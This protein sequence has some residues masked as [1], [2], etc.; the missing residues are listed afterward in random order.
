MKTQFSPAAVFRPPPAAGNGVHQWLASEAAKLSRRGISAEESA[1]ALFPVVRERRNSDGVAW[2]E[3]NAAVQSAQQKFP[4]RTRTSAHHHIASRAFM[5]TPPPPPPVSS[6]PIDWPKL[7]ALAL[8]GA[9]DLGSWKTDPDIRE[10]RHPGY[11]L[12]VLFPRDSLVCC[13]PAAPDSARTL[14]RD[15]WIARAE[16][17]ELVV[18]NP[19]TARRGV[20]QA[21][22]VSDRCL[23]N[24]GPWRWLVVEF[25]FKPDKPDAPATRRGALVQKLAEAGRTT[26]D[27]CAAILLHLAEVAP[28]ALVVHSGGKSLHGWF[29]APDCGRTMDTFQ[30]RAVALGA[31]SATFTR[32]Q[33]VRMPDGRRHDSGRPQYVQYINPLCLS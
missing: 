32:C 17:I 29:P 31:D 10:P 19:M 1:R 11:W 27:A 20:N 22:K 4:P 25:D 9:C 6:T 15:E 13:S 24:T 12:E 21:G 33:L 7:E 18:P 5:T 30:R 26:H 16:E 23:D 3:V 14:P 28:M 2:R 8:T